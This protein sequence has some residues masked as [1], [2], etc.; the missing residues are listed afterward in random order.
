MSET[1]IAS[2]GLHEG[3]HLFHCRHCGCVWEKY[4]DPNY[5]EWIAR[6]IGKYDGPGP[7]LGF[8]LDT[9]LKLKIRS[10]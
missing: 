7:E 4:R 3:G 2:V 1:D 5:D 6:R 9:R 10:F 8:V